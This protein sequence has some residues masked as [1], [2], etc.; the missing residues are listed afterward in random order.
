MRTIRLAGQRR[1]V[2]SVYERTSHVSKRREHDANENS[3]ALLAALIMI[4]I[5]FTMGVCG[6]IERGTI[7]FPM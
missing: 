5:L 4:A 2:G 3:N 6:G 1:A 7:P